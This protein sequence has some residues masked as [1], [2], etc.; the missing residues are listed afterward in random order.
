L[1]S[2][3]AGRRGAPSGR[4]EMSKCWYLPTDEAFDSQ[5]PSLAPTLQRPAADTAVKVARFRRSPISESSIKKQVAANRREGRYTRVRGTQNQRAEI[6][7]V[8]RRRRPSVARRLWP[9]AFR[10]VSFEGRVCFEGRPSIARA[11]FED[12]VASCVRSQPRRPAP[13]R[14]NLS[15]VA[16]L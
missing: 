6:I 2:V 14:Y 1:V 5:K 12:E 15:V 10:S 11:P 4:K 3:Q 8:G 16:V 13:D 9:D 7:K